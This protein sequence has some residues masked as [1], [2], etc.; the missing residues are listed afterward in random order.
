MYLN[1]IIMLFSKM[2]V[3]FNTFLVKYC[4]Y[5]YGTGANYFC[6]YISTWGESI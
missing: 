6:L 5:A 4:A 3:I 1:L 2:D